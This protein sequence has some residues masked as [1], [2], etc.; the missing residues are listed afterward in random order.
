MKIV[1]QIVLIVII[2]IL[3]VGFFK[4]SNHDNDE[5]Y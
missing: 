3:G 2:I 4:P 5:E 1:S